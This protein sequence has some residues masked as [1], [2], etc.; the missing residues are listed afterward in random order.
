MGSS[1]MRYSLGTSD[2]CRS[3]MRGLDSTTWR[4]E[5]KSRPSIYGASVAR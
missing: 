5:A 4:Y 3:D 2:W 1:G